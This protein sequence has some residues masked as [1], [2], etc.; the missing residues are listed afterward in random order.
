MALQINQ[1]VDLF[2]HSSDC[3][4]SL[5][6]YSN[7]TCA[8]FSKSSHALMNAIAIMNSYETARLR[9]LSPAKAVVLLDFDNL[10]RL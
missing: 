8:L 9:F 1:L 5:N 3:L 7:D 2:P 4:L 10:I 6:L